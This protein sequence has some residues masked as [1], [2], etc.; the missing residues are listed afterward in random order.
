MIVKFSHYF[1]DT[2][3]YEVFENIKDELASQGYT[4]D[5]DEFCQLV[6]RPFYEVT[7]HCELDTATGKVSIVG[8]EM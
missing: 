7:V 6:G 4:P 5:E 3:T 8:W 2:S 1:H